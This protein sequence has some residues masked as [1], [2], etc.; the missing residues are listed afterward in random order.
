VP[1][2]DRDLNVCDACNDMVHFKC[3]AHPATGYCD[4]CFE[5]YDLEDPPTALGRAA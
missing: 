5:K 1:T 2:P 4:R 3:S